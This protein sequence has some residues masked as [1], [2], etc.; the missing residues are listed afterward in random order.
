MKQLQK[1]KNE[2]EKKINDLVWDI[3][4]K[5]KNIEKIEKDIKESEELLDFLIKARNIKVEVK[6]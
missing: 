3:Q 6:V 4:M 2:M 1:E 5:K